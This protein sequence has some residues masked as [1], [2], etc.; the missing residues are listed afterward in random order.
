MRI[1]D[2]LILDALQK[3]NVRVKHVHGTVS[4][5]TV[6]KAETLIE[7]GAKLTEPITKKLKVAE[8]ETEGKKEEGSEKSKAWQLLKL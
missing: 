3:A 7:Q 5:N 1:L 6:L 8:P 2:V 4:K